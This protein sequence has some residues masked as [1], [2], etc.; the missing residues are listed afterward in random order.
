M[1]NSLFTWVLTFQ[2]LITRHSVNHNGNA[3]I[4]KP[5]TQ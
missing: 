2:I 4:L 5:L 3:H 1:L